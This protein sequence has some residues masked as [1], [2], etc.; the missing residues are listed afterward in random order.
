MRPGRA[1]NGR[2]KGKKKVLTPKT[3]LKDA[4]EVGLSQAAGADLSCAY[5]SVEFR[6]LS[7]DCSKNTLSAMVKNNFLLSIY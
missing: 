7:G 3:H 5:H 4:M 1:G 2:K 6:E